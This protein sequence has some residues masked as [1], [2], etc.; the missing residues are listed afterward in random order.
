MACRLSI[1]TF[2]ICFLLFFFCLAAAAKSDEEATRY[3]DPPPACPTEPL[4]PTET[5]YHVFW[6]ST[7]APRDDRLYF[8]KKS[9]VSVIP[10]CN[11]GN[12][13]K[14][15]LV[16]PVGLVLRKISE[17][18]I[19]HFSNSTDYWL[20]ETEYGIRF[21]IIKADIEE[22][23][24]NKIY[25]F[26]NTRTGRA[27]Y[28]IDRRE[29]CTLDRLTDLWDDQS[30]VLASGGGQGVAYAV[31][32]TINVVSCE[33][34][35]VKVHIYNN[36]T[37][38]PPERAYLDPC[39]LPA[40]EEKEDSSFDPT[41]WE[42]TR[43][44][45]SMELHRNQL[46]KLVSYEKMMSVFSNFIEKPDITAIS[47]HREY[48]N[49]SNN[50]PNNFIFGCDNTNGIITFMNAVG[51]SS[52]LSEEDLG[53]EI[54]NMKESIH[55]RTGHIFEKHKEESS[56]NNGI[57]PPIAYSLSIQ[58][59]K[60]DVKRSNE[61]SLALYFDYIDNYYSKRVEVS[62]ENLLGKSCSMNKNPSF[63]GNRGDGRHSSAYGIVESDVNSRKQG[64]LHKI[65]G[66]VDDYFYWLHVI[67]N[68]IQAN[69]IND[70]LPTKHE[71][72]AEFE[73]TSFYKRLNYL[74]HLVMSQIF[75]PVRQY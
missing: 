14:N 35:E 52:M 65:Q 3:T 45:R 15:F 23:K 62:F 70:E 2:L 19:D 34:L 9:G 18:K 12:E 56:A 38:H 60:C 58:T 71:G 63:C 33:I 42:S 11:N 20:V 10:D 22:L 51:R 7:D 29:E 37:W 49:I 4:S 75:Y 57:S 72:A 41:V 6:P 28:C 32:D 26:N 67:Q 30:T 25:F 54:S 74:S 24:Q 13:A 47:V 73:Y 64:Y 8:T 55:V 59:L 16:Y 53:R 61:H 43:I 48:A 69:A 68:Y 21:F 1:N 44:K 46:I 17:R 31:A 39:R 50:S 40:E 27:P 66:G 5:H 36:N